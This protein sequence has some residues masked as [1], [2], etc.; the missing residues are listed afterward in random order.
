[1]QNGLGTSYYP[2]GN[3]KYMGQWVSG[4]PHGNGTFYLPNAMRFEGEFQ[5][6]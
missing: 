3:I 1:M 2:N 6:G 4:S 5:N